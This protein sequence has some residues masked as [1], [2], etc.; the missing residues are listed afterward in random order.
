MNKN[1]KNASRLCSLSHDSVGERFKPQKLR[2]GKTAVKSTSWRAGE[3]ARWLRSLIAFAEVLGSI[4]QLPHGSTQ[5]SL[6]GS[7]ALFW[8]V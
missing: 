5:V 7:D 2:T 3:M 1:S 6:T 8:Y 4:P